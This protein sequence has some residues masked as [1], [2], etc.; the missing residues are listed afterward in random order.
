MASGYEKSPDYGGP[1][2][3]LW[4][5]IFVLVAA[6]C[7]VAAW[8]YLSGYGFMKADLVIISPNSVSLALLAGILYFKVKERHAPA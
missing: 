6:I 3:N 7:A 5:M 4:L 2:P 8:R 1:E